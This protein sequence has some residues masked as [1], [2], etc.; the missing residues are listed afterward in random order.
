MRTLPF[1]ILPLLLFASIIMGGAA[2]LPRAAHADYFVWQDPKTGTRLTYPDTWRTIN[3]QKR[4]DLVTLLGPD[5]AERPICRL[6]ARDD[7]RFTGY[8]SYFSSDIQH[9]EY[10]TEFWND[11]TGEY[12]DV[13]IHSVMDDAAV[14]K[15]FASL[16]VFGFTDAVAKTGQLRTGQAFA[17]IYFDKAYIFDCSVAAY[18][19][20]TWQPDFV[21]IA[22]SINMRPITSATPN[23]YY[24]FRAAFKMPKSLRAVNAADMAAPN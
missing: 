20:P 19:Y 11:Y 1:L 8:P 18:A 3:N 21:S 5:A 15:A 17:G 14:G 22:K 12:N 23:G 10:S 9:A 13:T 2:L 7:K 4:D 6:R 24:P 16:A